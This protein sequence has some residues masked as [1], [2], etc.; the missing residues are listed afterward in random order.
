MK[1]WNVH[2]CGRLNSGSR[3]V[4][5]NR[6]VGVGSAQASRMTLKVSSKGSIASPKKTK[7]RKTPVH[8]RATHMHGQVGAAG[9]I[10]LA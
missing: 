5:A 9:T 8:T 3:L 10:M 7:N 2:P 4:E 1:L 6:M